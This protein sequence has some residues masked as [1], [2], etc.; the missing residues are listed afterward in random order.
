MH[1]KGEL[2]IG[3][4]SFQKKSVKVGGELDLYFKVELDSNR[5]IYALN[6]ETSLA[7]YNAI[8]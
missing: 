8:M 4:T 7:P 1:K 6:Q 3:F 2:Q 5:L